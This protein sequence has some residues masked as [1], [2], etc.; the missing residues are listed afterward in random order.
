[1]Y[2]ENMTTDTP[3]VDDGERNTTLER[4]G[5]TAEPPQVPM[6]IDDEQRMSPE[7]QEAWRKA[8]TVTK[9]IARGTGDRVMGLLVCAGDGLCTGMGVVATNAGAGFWIA[10]GISQLV[11]LPAGAICGLLVG[12][13]FGVILGRKP[14]QELIHEYRE[15]FGTYMGQRCRV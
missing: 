14:A 11:A 15:S 6:C 5:Y 12:G 13:W 1:M 9:G 8:V 10:G 4:T 2:Q 3:V 7:L